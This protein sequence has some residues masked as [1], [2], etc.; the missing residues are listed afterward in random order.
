MSADMKSNILREID[1]F[2]TRPSQVLQLQAPRKAGAKPD[3]ALLIEQS[4]EASDDITNMFAAAILHPSFRETVIKLAEHDLSTRIKLDN[5]PMQN[6]SSAALSAE[7]QQGIFGLI[8]I[9]THLVGGLMS[10]VQS[11]NAVQ[12]NI[13]GAYYPG[14]PLPPDIQQGIFDTFTSFAKNPIFTNIIK[15]ILLKT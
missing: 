10:G 12:A 11:Q 9:L 2:D 6:P 1:L 15:D 14:K 8:P 4:T 3:N 13:G 7:V 5:F